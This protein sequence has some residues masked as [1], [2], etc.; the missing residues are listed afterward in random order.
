MKI[1]I[2]SDLHGN[3]HAL[4]AVLAAESWCDG[5][6]C[7]GDLVNYGPD[8]V[9]C[10]QW[11]QS[12]VSG[13]I[14]QGN[15]DH[16]LGLDADPRCSPPYRSLAA[17][18]QRYT[19]G[20]LTPDAR[21]YLAGL[22]RTLALTFG[23]ARF[24]S[25]TRRR[26]IRCLPTCRRMLRTSAGKPRSSARADRIFCS[27]GT[28]TC[29]SSNASARRLSP[30]PEVLVSRRIVIHALAMRCGRTAGS[31]LGARHTMCNLS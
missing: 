19:A 6:L 15:H 29:N 20:V 2:V 25:A 16:A 22:P 5:F 28:R 13:R 24:F 7:L 8:P 21:H 1:V 12:A 3:R 30:I 4:L 9:A 11:A 23:S 18:M 10:V 17:A 31:T 26:P 14:V 27:S